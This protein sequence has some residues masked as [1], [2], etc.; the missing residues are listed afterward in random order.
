MIFFADAKLMQSVHNL[1]ALKIRK[2]LSSR[3]L[4]RFRN[5]S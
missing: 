5:E 1:Y 2:D 4:L 3:T